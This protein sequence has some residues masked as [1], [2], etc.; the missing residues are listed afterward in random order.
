MDP[1]KGS[2]RYSSQMHYL[3]FEGLV[4]LYPN[5]SIQLAQAESYETSEDN[6]TFTFHLKNTVWSDNT[7]VTAY[8][9][10]QS[11]KDI[12]D[13]QFPSQQAKLFSPI[14]NAEAA[15][16]GL[17]SLDEVGIKAIDAKTLIVTLEKPTPYFFKLLA[18]AAFSPVNS[19]NDRK[20]PDWAYSANHN[21]LCNGPYLLE[22]WDH[23]NQIIAVRNFNYRKTQDLRP[24]RIVF[25]VIENDQTTLQMFEQGLIDVIGDALTDIPLEAIPRLEK[26][27]TISRKPRASTLFISLNT[28]KFP[29]NHPKIRKAL[30]F[31]INR[32]ELIG[33]SGKGVKKNILTDHI[34]IA[35]QASLAATNL[36]PPCL[37]EDRHRSFFKDNDVNQAKILLEEALVELGVDRKIFDSITFYHYSRFFG[38]TELMETIQ[39]QWLNALGVFIKIEYVDY[40]TAMSN[41]IAGDYNMCFIRRDV[42]YHDPM[43]VLER[44]KYKKYTKNYSNWEN[45][46]YIQLLDKS[47]YVEGDARFQVLEQAERVL[48]RDMPVIPLYHED[49]MYIINPDLKYKIPL[50]GDRLLLPESFEDQNL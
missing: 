40:Q 9:F 11:W 49:F 35:Y 18:C 47:F 31:A 2:D 21:F 8:D 36:I 29:F 10:E 39:K 19:K 48:L 41:L 14:K 38:A 15:K 13:P 25:N 26:K 34:N 4:K 6:L 17:V 22:K 32:K 16:E 3:F 7:P 50:Y 44:F 43:S 12:L 45:Q 30:S 42:I 1:R 5:G 33:S 46:E 20:H 28:D 27:W 37:K 23:K 24:E